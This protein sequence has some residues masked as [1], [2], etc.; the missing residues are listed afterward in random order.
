MSQYDSIVD[1]A[2]I[3]IEAEEWQK[4]INSLHAHSLD[5]LHYAPGRKDGSVMDITYNDGFVQRTINSTGEIITFGKRLKGEELI[6]D[7]ARK[8]K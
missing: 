7:Y 2:R 3:Q 6:A 4:G 8:S 5:S 1:R